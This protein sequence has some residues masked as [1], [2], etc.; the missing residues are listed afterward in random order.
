MSMLK[1]VVFGLLTV[2]LLGVA[3]AFNPGVVSAQSSDIDPLEG[4]GTDDDGSGPFGGGDDPFDLFHRAVLAPS[5][6]RDE[7]QEQQQRAITSEAE[8]FRLRQQEALRQQEPA[9]SES[10][11]VDEVGN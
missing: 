4:L 7:F 6:G 11:S 9:A 2:S 3:L 10:V 1:N 5:M 8:S